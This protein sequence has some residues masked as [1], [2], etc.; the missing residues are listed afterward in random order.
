[1]LGALCVGAWKQRGRTLQ[2]NYFGWTW[3]P[4]GLNPTGSFNLLET[5]TVSADGNSYTGSF[6]FKPYDANGVFEPSGEHKGTI[7]ATRITQNTLGAD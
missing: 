4:S 6:D 3:D 7:A 1:M 2:L 5:I